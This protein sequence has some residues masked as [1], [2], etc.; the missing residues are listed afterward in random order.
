MPKKTPYKN[1]INFYETLGAS[2]PYSSAS[3]VQ[4]ITTSPWWIYTAWIVGSIILGI[5]FGLAIKDF[6]KTNDTVYSGGIVANIRGADFKTAAA[7]LT[8]AQTQPVSLQSKGA[9]LQGN[10]T[11]LQP[12]QAITSL[13]NGFSGL[14]QQGTV[15]V[16]A[17][18][19]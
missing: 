4:S 1:E 2:L 19:R 3:P 17:I 14:G 15:G 8:L 13:Q 12:G 5:L 6:Q 11:V 16:P 7:G 18:Y 10:S 9:G